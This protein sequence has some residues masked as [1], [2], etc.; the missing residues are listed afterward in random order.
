MLSRILAIVGLFAML[1]G[2]LDPLEGS[3]IIVPGVA[4]ATLG[5]FLG[6]SRFTKLFY[7]SLA[8]VA[9]GV[10]AMFTIGAVGG[11]GARRGYLMWWG[12]LIA[13]YPLG[14]LLGLVS[15]V[16]RVI[17]SFRRHEAPGLSANA[18]G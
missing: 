12:L 5:A 18:A 8:L 2:G 13:P 11:L 4:I 1:V 14:Y 17:E 7:W 9:L 6:H 3:V 16:L 15:G 10:A